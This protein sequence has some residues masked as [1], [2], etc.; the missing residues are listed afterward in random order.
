MRALFLVPAALQALV[1][2]GDEGWF[3]RR[4]GLPRFV[5]IRGHRQ[6]RFLANGI[7]HPQSGFQSWPAK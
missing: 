6:T 4:R 7:E 1:M 3:H 5:D 2:L